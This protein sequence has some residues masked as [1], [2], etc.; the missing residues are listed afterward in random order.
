MTQ[1]DELRLIAAGSLKRALGEVATV[2]T[3]RTGV[4][5]A[6]TFGPSGLMRKRIEQGEVFHLF[7]SANMK[8]P[9]ALEAAGLAGGVTL[10]VRNKLCALAQSGLT[11]GPDTLLETLLRPD[12]R[13]GTSTPKA[14]PSGDYA[15]ALFA[16]AEA[17]REGAR[18]ALEK[19]ALQLTGGPTSEPAPKGRNQYAWVMENGRADIFLTYCT[20]A[21]LAKKQVPDLQI[22]SIP[23]TL[24]VGADYGLTILN[25]APLQ[26]KE[27]ARFI[28]SAEGQAVFA[29][30]G[31]APAAR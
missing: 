25:G 18:T 22:I 21:V 13:V 20:N 17:V 24:G 27:L 1:A 2:F 28:L 6:T 23:E 4:T 31:F 29:R 14:D 16:R 11:V 3:E 12:V 9:R 15:F 8:H 7:A 5:V 26:A 10:F 30:Y 19:K